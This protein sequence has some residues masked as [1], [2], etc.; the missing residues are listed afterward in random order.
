MGHAD[1]PHREPDAAALRLTAVPPAAHAARPHG[2]EVARGDV[3]DRE[4][5]RDADEGE[6]ELLALEQLVDS[7]QGLVDVD[8]FVRPRRAEISARQRKLGREKVGKFGRERRTFAFCTWMNSDRSSVPCTADLS[9]ALMS[10]SYICMTAVR[11]PICTCRE[12]AS[13]CGE[14]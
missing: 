3:H 13:S 7:R 2:A 14:E 5:G 6:R 12:S 9:G 4:R 10:S 8:L 11:S 1:G